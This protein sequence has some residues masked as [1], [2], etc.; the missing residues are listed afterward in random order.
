MSFFLYVF[1][2]QIHFD[3]ENMRFLH[4]PE[5]QGPRN[6]ENQPQSSFSVF[7]NIHFLTFGQFLFPTFYCT[8]NAGE[9]NYGDGYE[10]DDDDDWFPAY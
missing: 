10:Y 8:S 2:S 7:L 1:E 3:Y 6:H 4:T 5:G 9:Y